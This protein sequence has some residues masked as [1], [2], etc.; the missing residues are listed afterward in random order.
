MQI[1]TFKVLDDIDRIAKESKFREHVTLYILKHPEK[2]R[3]YNL[4]APRELNYPDWH[5]ELDEEKDYRLIKKIYESL[6]PLNKRFTTSDIISLLKKHP[7]WL[8]INRDV[9]RAWEEARKEDI[10]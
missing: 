6:Y 10:V 4:K 2:Y 9:K 7:E 5:L 1:F 8:L 3:L